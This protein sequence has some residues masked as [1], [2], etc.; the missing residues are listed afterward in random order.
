MF[1][2]NN[3]IWYKYRNITHL[4][5]AGEALPQTRPS[6]DPPG[7]AP[8]PIFKIVV[9]AKYFMFFVSIPLVTWRGHLCD[10]DIDSL[11][12]LKLRGYGAQTERDPV[13]PLRHEVALDIRDVDEVLLS[14]L[15]LEEAVAPGPA[16]VSH[17]P[18]L[19]ITLQIVGKLFYGNIK[20][21][22]AS[23]SKLFLQPAANNRIPSIP[24]CE[25]SINFPFYKCQGTKH[26]SNIVIMLRILL[27]TLI[28]SEMELVL[29]LLG[30][31]VLS[32]R[33][34]ESSKLEP[35]PESE[36]EM[37]RDLRLEM[38]PILSSTALNV[39]FTLTDGCYPCPGG[40]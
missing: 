17:L 22:A 23:L 16:E 37:H 13:S 20:S 25:S 26:S 24:F 15:A 12:P 11:G 38:E 7:S 19:D 30:S 40:S 2:P 9:M 32:R 31:R 6:P 27:V 33:R 1:F 10:L 3:I 36:Q 5:G 21:G 18:C 8:H 4:P 28:L 35:T 34:L 14:P 29:D 39:V